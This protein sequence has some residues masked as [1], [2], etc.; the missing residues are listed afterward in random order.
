MSRQLSEAFLNP[1]PMSTDIQTPTA[2]LTRAIIDYAD[3]HPVITK[4]AIYNTQGTKILDKGA[5]IHAGLYDRLMAHQLSRPLEDS[6]AVEGMVDGAAIRKG[7]EIVMGFEPFYVRLVRQPQQLDRLLGIIEGIPLPEAVA[8]QLTIARDVRPSLYDHALRTAWTMAWLTDDPLRPQFDIGMAA[9]AGLLHDLGMLHLNPVLMDHKVELTRELRRELYSHPIVSTLLVE[10]HH[11]YPQE[12]VRAVMEH[13]EYLNGSGYP[14]NL[15]GRQ[16]SLMGQQLALTDLVVAMISGHDDG[17]E[18]RLSVLLRMNMHRYA[19]S[20][21]DRVL[22]ALDPG[23]D[24]RSQ[25]VVSLDTPGHVLQQVHEALQQWPRNFARFADITPV[26][27]E[28][29]AVVT[30]LVDELLRTLAEAGL[31]PGQLEQL[32]NPTEDPMLMKEL[33]LLARE[34]VWQLRALSRQARRRWAAG[35]QG[36]YPKELQAWLTHADAL[37]QLVNGTT[38]GQEPMYTRS[39][40]H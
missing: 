40:T 8:L 36:N 31:T 29:M 27:R 13:H 5:S 35:K 30:E 39:T 37:N 7:I 10:R 17:G 34:A 9:A 21:I 14:R 16:I 15:H 4:E 25:T 38:Q 33:S 24:P 22:A 20:L 28:G 23:Q 32:G 6:L 12:V 26:R 18:L 19:R 1:Q 2:H 3:T 11:V